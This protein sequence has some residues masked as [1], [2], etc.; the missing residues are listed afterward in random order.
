MQ[1]IVLLG[2]REYIGVNYFKGCLN[3]EEKLPAL[4]KNRKIRNQIML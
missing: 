2:E 3:Y 4:R 1:S